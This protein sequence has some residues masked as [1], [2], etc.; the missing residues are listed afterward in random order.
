MEKVKWKRGDEVIAEL[1]T[2]ALTNTVDCKPILDYL[3]KILDHEIS[4]GYKLNVSIGTDSQKAGKPGV[5]KFATV[6]LISTYE[7]LGGGVITEAALIGA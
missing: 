5:Y 1:T 2:N 4:R 3:T 7:D 6:I